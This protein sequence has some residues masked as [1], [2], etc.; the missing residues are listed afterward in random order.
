MEAVIWLSLIIIL[1]MVA[2]AYYVYSR[3]RSNI[4]EYDK[5]RIYRD[6]I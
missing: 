4:N 2:I 3:L 5:L 6:K 1:V